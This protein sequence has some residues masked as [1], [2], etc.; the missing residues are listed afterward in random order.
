MTTYLL[1][2][3]GG[4]MADTEAEQQEQMAAWGAWFGSLGEAVVDGGNPFAGS[5]SVGSDGSVAEGAG[6]GL[7]GYSVLQADSL[8]AAAQLATGCPLIG[9]GGTV[10]VY[11]TIPM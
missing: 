3:K 5:V 7:G 6:S 9:N 11:E 2:Y 10:D 1:A 4:K 8:D